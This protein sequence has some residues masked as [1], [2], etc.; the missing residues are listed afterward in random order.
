MAS[1]MEELM[2][3]L[4]KESAE[5]EV[6]L[7]LST[8]KTPAIVSG[9]IPALQTITDREQT[10]VSNIGGL[11]RKREEIVK[12]M[13]IVLNRDRG[14]LRIKNIIQFLENRPEEQKRLAIVHDRLSTAVRGMVK[15][16]EQNRMLIAHSMEMI[17][18]DLN[19][20][21]SMRQ[22]PEVAN[23]TRGANNAAVL[24]GSRGSFDTKQ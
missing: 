7:A 13:A 8:E 3:V 12:D 5:Y 17:E 4:E 15:I 24:T 23:Y 22:A 1:L 9:D 14:S 16:N 20:F 6:L 21:R 19:L 11:E 10:V 18:F 2:D